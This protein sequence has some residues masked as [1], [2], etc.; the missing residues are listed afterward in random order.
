MTIVEVSRNVLQKPL[1][2]VLRW[3]P[4]A[5]AVILFT[6]NIILAYLGTGLETLVL[7]SIFTVMILEILAQEG[8]NS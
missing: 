3:V 8:I 1:P 2:P 4:A 7:V 6:P 5:V